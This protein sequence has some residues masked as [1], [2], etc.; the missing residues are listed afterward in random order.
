MK[1]LTEYPDARAMIVSHFETRWKLIESRSDIASIGG[2]FAEDFPPAPIAWRKRGARLVE[3]AVDPI[4][5]FNSRRRDVPNST[6]TN[7]APAGAKTNASSPILFR[8]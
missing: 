4:D 8:Q 2:R 1:W 3:G 5:R 6:L 7:P